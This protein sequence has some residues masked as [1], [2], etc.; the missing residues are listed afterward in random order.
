M[1]KINEKSLNDYPKPIFIEGTEIILN[2]MKK[3]ICKISTESG[4]KGTGFF[5]KIPY[6][7]NDLKVFITNNHVIDEA[8]LETQNV[9]YIS[10]NNNPKQIKLDKKFKY[11]NKENDVTIVEIKEN[12]DEIIDFLELDENKVLVDYCGSS[13][14]AIQYPSYNEIQKPA[15]SY[16]ILKKRLDNN[17][18]DFIHYCSTEHGSSGSP[19]LNLS[20]YKIIGIHKQTTHKGQ[21]NIGVFLH[22]IIKDFID[23]YNKKKNQLL[24][25]IKIKTEKEVKIEANS[26]D[27]IKIKYK[28]NKSKKIRLF[29]DKFVENNKKKCKIVFDKKEE[30]LVSWKEIDD[31]KKTFLEI[32]LKGLKNI[33]NMSNIFNGCSLLVSMPDIKKMNMKNVTDISCAFSGCSSIEIMPDISDWDTS[34][35]TDIGSLFSNCR[36]LKSLPD[37]SKWNTDR[38]TN[39]SY[40]FNGCSSLTSIPN[41]SKWKINKT[42]KLNNIFSNCSQITC[43]PDIS[44]WNTEN[45]VNMSYMFSGC[46][47]LKSLP[48][49]S[50]WNT[51][52]VTD[53]ESIFSGCSSIKS[54]PDI[55]NW[56]IN[57]KLMAN[58]M[59]IIN[60][61][62]KM[63]NI[64]NICNMHNLNYLNN[65]NNLNKKNNFLINND[66]N[67][68]ISN[69]NLNKMNEINKYNN[70]I[71]K[72]GNKLIFIEFIYENN[73]GFININENQKFS[74][75]IEILNRKYKWIKPIDRKKFYLDENK[76]IEI[77]KELEIY[78]IKFDYKPLI[79]IKQKHQF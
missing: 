33:T 34:N 79:Y 66:N 6:P 8:Y 37:L 64:N 27:K 60:S 52:K 7:D 11:T 68:I 19:I 47:K 78:S 55:S 16:G 59:K 57:K 32:I 26:I 48:D 74:E 62:N 4:S 31:I 5:C 29:G 18:Y 17:N 75:A 63:N 12:V 25:N 44:N 21:Y 65:L 41:I 50:K 1:S 70:N 42:T 30:D 9:I 22:N 51:K 43:L 23:K 38:V 35:I 56:N 2:Q 20:N 76:S 14:Y 58:N 72:N 61:I 13:I 36:S 71:N 3:A 45:V 49:L 46:I 28:I 24:G 54:L 40:V 67:I 39:M 53:I 73:K 77:K 15:V 69:N 10:I